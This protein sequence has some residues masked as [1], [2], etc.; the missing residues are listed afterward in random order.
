VPWRSLGREARGRAGAARDLARELERRRR[1]DGEAFTVTERKRLKAEQKREAQEQSRAVEVDGPDHPE[2]WNTALLAYLATDEFIDPRWP[3]EAAID[4][5]ITRGS[6]EDV[7]YQEQ[8]PKTRAIQVEMDAG[9]RHAQ[10][11]LRAIDYTN[12]TGSR[13]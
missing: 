4:A 7:A 2:G 6:D 10:E 11:E 1:L 9:L 3:D 13:G 8:D 12:Q 5:E